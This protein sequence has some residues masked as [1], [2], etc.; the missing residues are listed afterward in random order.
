M[1]SR[2]RKLAKRVELKAQRASGTKHGCDTCRA[3][4]F[5]QQM[6]RQLIEAGL[7]RSPTRLVCPVCTAIWVVQFGGDPA[8]EATVSFTVPVLS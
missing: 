1:S 7:V 8:G 2:A 5:R 4:D 6:T 3:L